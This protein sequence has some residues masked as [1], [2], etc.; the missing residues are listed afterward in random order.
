MD[1]Q[2]GIVSSRLRKAQERLDAIRAGKPIDPEPQAPIVSKPPANPLAIKR[3][4]PAATQATASKAAP[5]AQTAPKARTGGKRA[6]SD[7][8]SPVLPARAV[9]LE[10]ETALISMFRE[11]ASNAPGI[12]LCAADMPQIWSA[13]V[14]GAKRPGIQGAADRNQLFKVLGMSWMGSRSKEIDRLA[15]AIGDRL[16]RALSRVSEGQRHIPVTLQG[17]AEEIASLP[18]ASSPIAHKIPQPMPYREGDLEGE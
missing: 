5:A 2:P 6:N 12:E 18:A 16:G 4:K 9:A 13:M 3:T 15:S 17:E 8:I 11:H 1:L 14:E 10:P 7:P